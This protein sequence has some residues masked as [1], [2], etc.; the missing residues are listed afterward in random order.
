MPSVLTKTKALLVEGTNEEDFSSP[1]LTISHI[2]IS[3]Y[4]HTPKIN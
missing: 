4:S 1:F 3:S 2:T